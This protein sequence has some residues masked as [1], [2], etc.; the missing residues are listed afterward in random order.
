[1]R[2]RTFYGYFPQLAAYEA[3]RTF[4]TSF[5]SFS[6]PSTLMLGRCASRGKIAAHE[7]LPGQLG[8]RGRGVHGPLEALPAFRIGGIHQGKAIAQQHLLRGRIVGVGV[9]H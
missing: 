7:Q 1:M 9:G 6:M 4:S 2:L 5:L 8:R 3:T